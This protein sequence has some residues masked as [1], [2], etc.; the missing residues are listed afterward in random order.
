M[1]GLCL[2]LSLFLAPFV[3]SQKRTFTVSELKINDERPHFSL[4]YSKNNKVHYIS[5]LLNK[6]GKIKTVIG[7]P[8][9][10]VFEA[11]II[12][13]DIKSEIPIVLAEGVTMTNVSSV[14]LSPEGK[15]L[16]VTVTYNN[17]N[18]PKGDFS[19]ENFHIEVGEF[20]AGVGWTNFKVLPFCNPKYS[21][22]H[23]TF[24][25][26]GKTM[27]F[28]ANI[29]GGKEATKGASDIFKVDVLGNNTFSEPINLGIKVNSFSKEMYPFISDD[30]TLYFASNR[31]NGFGGFDIY[32]SKM[33]VDGSFDKAEKLPEPINSKQD[34]F[35]FVIDS[36]NRTGF[37]SSKRTLGGK[38]EDDIYYFMS[39]E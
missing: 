28:I 11:E 32:K 22:G 30:N 12:D 20:V 4:N 9:L 1:K 16:Y 21:Y 27:Y 8:I 18:S 34:D 29:K 19:I 39:L 35:C 25:K 31:P 23:P 33:T 7:E 24:S 17:K 6:N 37:F 38:G 15:H 3:F 36:K 5:Y 2:L 13:N 10:T 14:I 26:D